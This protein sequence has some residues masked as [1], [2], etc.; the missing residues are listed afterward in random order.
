M[1][2][3]GVPVPDI[4]NPHLCGSSIPMPIL[5]EPGHLVLELFYGGDEF[6]AFRF[7]SRIAVNNLVCSLHYHAG[8]ENSVKN[9]LTTRG[10]RP[11]N[12]FIVAQLCI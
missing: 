5:I 3:I 2:D 1:Q 10:H 7:E 11:A 9:E 12:D 8:C 4:S 6:L